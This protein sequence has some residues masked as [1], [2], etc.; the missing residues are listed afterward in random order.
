MTKAEAG[1]DPNKLLTKADFARMKRVS[2]VKIL[3]E[4]LNLT[5]QEFA[6]RFHIPLGTLRDWEQNR[7]EPDQTARAYLTVL[8]RY[9]D[10]VRCALEMTHTPRKRSD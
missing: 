9:P 3:R 6:T 4:S 1:E 10:A 8:A 2:R 5:Q 7:K